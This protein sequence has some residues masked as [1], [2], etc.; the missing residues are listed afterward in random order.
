MQC[1]HVAVRIYSHAHAHTHRT[2]T[3][4][5]RAQSRL[6]GLF[7]QLTASATASAS[8][9]GGYQRIT[10]S[11]VLRHTSP[12]S[13]WIVRGSKVY[14]VTKWL[15]RHPGGEGVILSAAGTDCTKAFDAI[16]PQ[17]VKMLDKWVVGEVEASPQVRYG[18]PPRPPCYSPSAS[19]PRPY[20][21]P[22]RLAWLRSPASPARL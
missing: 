19:V 18:P 17:Y 3:R 5:S 22:L 20:R 16:H 2:H 7:R 4:R 10:W 21:R 11:E 9:G 6:S 1:T 8:D 14:D 15:Q 13:C 12:E